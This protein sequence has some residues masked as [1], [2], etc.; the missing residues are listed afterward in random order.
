METRKI[1]KWEVAV[2]FLQTYIVWGITMYTV[3]LRIGMN[4]ATVPCIMSTIAIVMLHLSVN[5]EL[6]TSKNY[7]K[8]YIIHIIMAFANTCMIYTINPSMIWY[9]YVLLGLLTFIS[10]TLWR[11]IS[12]KYHKQQYVKHL[13]IKD[14]QGLYD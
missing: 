11:Y 1:H 9:H 12:Y 10:P 2:P 4:N 3:F 6:S 5:V 13:I 8:T 14:Q 7:V